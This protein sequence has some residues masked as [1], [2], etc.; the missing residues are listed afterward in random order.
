[1]GRLPCER[2][3]MEVL[4][5]TPEMIHNIPQPRFE[6]FVAEALEGRGDVEL[7]KETSF[8]GLVQVSRFWIH[9]EIVSLCW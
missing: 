9:G 5:D 8:V 2:M 3:D 6:E 7:R 1:M 4:R